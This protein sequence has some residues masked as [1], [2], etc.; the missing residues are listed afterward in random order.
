MLIKT[1]H[2]HLMIRDLIL[3]TQKQKCVHPCDLYEGWC[4]LLRIEAVDRCPCEDSA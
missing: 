2:D 4:R 3:V 1:I